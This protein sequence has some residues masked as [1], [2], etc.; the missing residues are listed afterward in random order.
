M[1]TDEDGSAVETE[2]SRLRFVSSSLSHLC[3]SVPHLW[4]TSPLICVHLR[5][6]P[7]PVPRRVIGTCVCLGHLPHTEARPAKLGPPCAITTPVPAAA[8]F[9]RSLTDLP[10]TGR[11]IKDRPYRQV[12][13]FTHAGVAYYLKFYPRAGSRLKRRIRGNPAMRE[14]RRLQW[15]QQADVPAPRAVAVMLGFKIAGRLGDAVILEALEPS[16]TLAQYLDDKLLRAHP[17]ADHRDLAQ[18]VRTLLAKLHTAGLG[19]A[20]LHL[21]NF[22]LRG[23][24]LF[25]L[26][27]YAVHRRGLKRRD[28]MLLAHSA[29]RVATR[30]DILR[31]WYRLGFDKLPPRA[32]RLRQQLARKFVSKATTGDGQYFGH[33]ASGEWSGYFTRRSPA[34][35][36]WSQ[37]SQMEMTDAQWTVL[38]SDLL[39]RLDRD[40][41]EVLKRSR[42]GDVLAGT[43]TLGDRPLDVILK[44]PRRKFWWRYLNEI[45]RGSRARRAWNKAWALA[46]RDLPTA[47][48]LAVM[49]KRHLGYVTDAVILFE[50]LPGPTLATIDL[51]TLT[52]TDRDTLF[53]RAG[54]LLRDMERDGL[55]HWDAKAWNFIVRPDPA[56][57]PQPMLIDV[58]S[59]RTFQ[60]T[61]IAIHRLLRSL[62][63]N[64]TYTPTD[65]KALCQGYAP[66]APLHRDPP[67]ATDT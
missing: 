17:I 29:R 39:T 56:L 51:N 19:H 62:H 32:N 44:R 12:W 66:H 7:L 61:R 37:L 53:R 8:D 38:W 64:P 10:R 31:V 21:G 59:I 55:Y 26:D 36:R 60:Y 18:Q 16:T 27:G 40:D 65:S 9:S 11:L 43:I 41:F 49:E 35:R 54:R 14:F 42:S 23:K 28:L 58:D 5:F 6:P 52:P 57:G 45:G 22:L 34:P 2:R 47:L 50:K 3:P 30:A 20:D 24:K 4:L 46:I 48:P 67:V 63:D 25:L 13:R 1:N 33:V 15:L